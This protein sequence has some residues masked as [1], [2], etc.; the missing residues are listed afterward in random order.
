MPRKARANLVDLSVTR[1]YHITSHCGR[2]ASLKA[3]GTD[4]RKEAIRCALERQHHLF[5]VDVITYSLMDNHFHLVVA[6]RPE[7]VAAWSPLEVARRWATLHPPRINGRVMKPEATERV[8]ESLAADPGWVEITRAKLSN[9]GQF[10]KDLKQPLA[11]QANREEG[12]RG[13]FW[14]GRFGSEPITSE[15]QLLAVL[16]YVDLNPFA[17]G[18]CRFP[19]E[20]RH[21]GLYERLQSCRRVLD[22]VAG[23]VEADGHADAGEDAEATGRC[24]PDSMPS[25]GDPEER[26]YGA[27]GALG[28]GC[29]AFVERPERYIWFAPLEEG[30]EG[31]LSNRSGLA[32]DLRRR[33][34]PLF[35]SRGFRLADYLKVVDYVA[36]LIREGKAHLDHAAAPILARV[37]LTAKQFVDRLEALRARLER[38]GYSFSAPFPVLLP[39]GGT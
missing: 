39:A 13:S 1:L 36:R 12:A 10:M 18:A 26:V 7:E 15:E 3:D 19:E 23:E 29:E 2:G 22:E 28:M 14:D 6:I 5:G 24:R 31:T 25:P 4:W 35:P 37:G 34:R 32:P 33:S 11:Q 30:T 21:T 8:I 9:L 27:A 16:A 20:G 38:R 17:A